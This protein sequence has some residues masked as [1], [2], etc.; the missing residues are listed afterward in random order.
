MLKAS[1]SLFL[2]LDLICFRDDFVDTESLLQSWRLWTPAIEETRNHMLRCGGN[3]GPP[4]GGWPVQNLRARNKLGRHCRC[5]WNALL[6][7]NPPCWC[8]WSHGTV[9][10]I[11]AVGCGAAE[12]YQFCSNTVELL[13]PLSCISGYLVFSILDTA[14]V[15]IET[16]LTLC[17]SL[18]QCLRYLPS[19]SNHFPKIKSIQVTV[20]V[21]TADLSINKK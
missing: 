6:W 20:R 14:T 15:A 21:A 10:I 4:L 19:V 11:S 17:S 7:R 18:I 1:L 13:Y 9:A 16:C 2:C 3:T 5:S 8:S 12:T